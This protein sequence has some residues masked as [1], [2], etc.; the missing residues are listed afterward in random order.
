M[1]SFLSTQSLRGVGRQVP[2]I[3]GSGCAISAFQGGGMGGW[4]GGAVGP[5]RVS[6]F[7]RR[8]LG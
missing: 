1:T 3:P 6:Q 2:S 4:G 8:I 7:S 5:I